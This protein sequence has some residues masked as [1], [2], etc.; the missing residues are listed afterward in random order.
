M[1]AS[2]LGT[3]ALI[4]NAQATPDPP[5]SRWIL[6]DDPARCQ[7]ERQNIEP[8]AILA[9]ETVPGIDS[10]NVT[11]ASEK[12][13][14]STPLSPAALTFAPSRQKL[15]G[16]ARAIKLP[17]GMPVLQMQGVALDFLT[18]LEHAET[19]TITTNTGIEGAA[20]VAGAA[21]AVEALRKCTADQLIDWGADAGQFAPG[22]KSPVALKDRDDWL[23]NK[24]LIDIARQSRQSD[25]DALFRVTITVDGIVDGCRA[26]TDNIRSGIETVACGAVVGKT[27]FTTAKDAG[28]HPVRGVA[29]FRVGLNRRPS[30]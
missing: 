13:K 14:G 8:P 16:L 1:I 5:V 7:L 2:L 20:Q 10:Y 28:D 25:V 23:S 22:G 9:I 26:A 27:L 6:R 3:L 15:N 30:L 11:I 17:N 29:T 24:E 12:I 19:V 21:K 18:G 4:G